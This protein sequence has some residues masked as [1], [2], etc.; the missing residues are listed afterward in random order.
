MEWRGYVKDRLNLT[1]KP[2]AFLTIRSGDIKL[3]LLTSANSNFSVLEMPLNISNGDILLV[4]DE[5]GQKK[6]QGVIKTINEDDLTIET[7]QIQ[8]IL[9]GMWFY[10]INNSGVLEDSFVSALKEF[11]SGKMKNSTYIDTLIEES[12]GVF[13]I[14]SVTSTSGNFE[15]QEDNYTIDMEQF[16]YDMYS[17]YL[18]MVDIDIKYS[19]TPTIKVGKSTLDS[20]KVGDNINT[21]VDIAP[22]LEVEETNRLI[23]YSQDGVYR[24][25]YVVK[26]DGTRVQ[27][28]TDTT[29]RFS[30]VNTNIVFSDDELADILEANLPSETYNHKLTFTLY[31]KSKIFNFDNFV[32]GMPLKVWRSS[33]Y[34]NTILTGIEFSKEENIDIESYSFTCG[35]VRT[36]LTKKILMRYGVK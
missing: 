30:L 6:Y 32:L 23:V 31:S 15:T 19:G 29:N 33:N 2:K 5:K 8:N 16:I 35:K 14:S 24:T 10:N 13:D 22:T 36:S 1:D 20:M 9:S 12:L 34:Y 26:G 4:Y 21:I 25:T 27:E 7:S 18:I 3:D 28:P 17:N 11:C